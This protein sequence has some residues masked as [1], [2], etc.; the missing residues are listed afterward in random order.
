[1]NHAIALE[2]L[3]DDNFDIVLT[4]D[5]N[6]INTGSVLWKNSPW[7]HKFLKQ[8]YDTHNDTTITSIHSWWEQAGIIHLLQD[9]DNMFH[10]RVLP[11]RSMNAWPRAQVTCSH[12]VYQPGDFVVH[13]PGDLRQELLHFIADHEIP[14]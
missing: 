10:V 4:R 3:V 1:M 6:G 12:Q 11:A 7:T 14:T 9:P 13:F 5:C 2:S 8:V